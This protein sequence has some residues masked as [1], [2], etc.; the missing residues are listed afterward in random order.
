MRLNGTA[1][2]DDVA[3]LLPDGNYSIRAL[4]SSEL[5]QGRIVSAPDSEILEHPPLEEDREKLI[6]L[7]FWCC[8]EFPAIGSR[9]ENEVLY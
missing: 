6:Q 8:E 5:H 7:R 9:S 2:S 3:V 1:D 4:D